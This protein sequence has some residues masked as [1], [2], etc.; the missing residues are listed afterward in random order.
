MSLPSLY[1]GMTRETLLSVVQPTC[2]YISS[3][4]TLFHFY[5]WTTLIF[6]GDP[7]YDERTSRLFTNNRWHNSGSFR[8]ELNQKTNNLSK[9]KQRIS[10]WSTN[11]KVI[12]SFSHYEC[13]IMCIGMHGI[14]PPAGGG[15]QS[16]NEKGRTT[17]HG[18]PWIKGWWGRGTW[19]AGTAFRQGHPQTDGT[20]SIRE[21]LPNLHALFCSTDV[22]CF[23]FDLGK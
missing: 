7:T 15:R 17:G 19:G 5:F 22:C 9:C 10:I 8:L 23:S 3:F 1:S 6:A 13:F 14:H 4:H 21:A 12:R 2:L 20:E 11:C 16:K 18:W